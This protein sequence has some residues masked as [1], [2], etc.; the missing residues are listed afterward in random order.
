MDSSGRAEAT[1]VN[2][3]VKRSI[4]GSLFR[5]PFLARAMADVESEIVIH[6]AAIQV[7]EERPGHV[8]HHLAARAVRVDDRLMAG[9]PFREPSRARGR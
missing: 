1:A 8:G 9:H 5:L 7:P 3:S 6:V 2:D 4:T